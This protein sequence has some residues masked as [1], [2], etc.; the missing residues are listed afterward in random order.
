MQEFVRIMEGIYLV[1]V[2][3]LLLVSFVKKKPSKLLGFMFLPLGLRILWVYPEKK[4]GGW[5]LILISLLYLFRG[6]RVVAYRSKPIWRADVGGPASD[7]SQSR[8]GR[9]WKNAPKALLLVS[10]LLIG[11]GII[12]FFVKQF[13][14]GVGEAVFRALL[15]ATALSIAYLFFDVIGIKMIGPVLSL[16]VET[17]RGVIRDV[18]WVSELRGRSTRTNLHILLEEDR[19]CF[20]TYALYSKK[21]TDLIGHECEYRVHTGILGTEF[22]LELPRKLSET[23]THTKTPEPEELSDLFFVEDSLRN[24]ERE[25][26]FFRNRWFFFSFFGLSLLLLVT[27]CLLHL[28]VR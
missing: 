7:R 24:Q 12:R 25:G 4:I 27:I 9:K 5:I 2:I 10:F 15:A 19:T 11:S 22:L 28:F 21:W 18:L 13:Q 26:F 17:R 14:L 3:F 23:A 8:I 16:K 20:I 6:I 1:G